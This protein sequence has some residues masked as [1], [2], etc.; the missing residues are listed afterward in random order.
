VRTRSGT[1]RRGVPL[2][3]FIS[4][5]RERVLTRSVDVE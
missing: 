2:E 3:E 4:D 5:A 1:D